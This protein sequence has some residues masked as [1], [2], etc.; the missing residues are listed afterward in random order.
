MKNNLSKTKSELTKELEEL[1]HAYAVLQQKYDEKATKLISEGDFTKFTEGISTAVFIYQ[2]DNFV[3]FNSAAKEIFG[4]SEEEFYKIKFW[5]LVHPDFRQLVKERGIARQ[6]GEHVPLNYEFKIITKNGNEKWLDYTAGNT[7][8]KGKPAVIGSAFDITSRKNTEQELLKFKLC[9]QGSFE[10]TFITDIDGTI[11]FANPAFETIYGYNQAEVIGNTPRILKSGTFSPEVYKNFW[12]T[13]LS[14]KAVA[15]EIINKTKNG[16]LISVEGFNT[17]ILDAD[18]N[19]FGFIGIHRDITEQKKSEDAI[20]LFKTLIDQSNDAI[21]VVDAKTGRFVNVNERGLIDLGYSREEFLKLNVWDVDPMVDESIFAKIVEQLKIA[22]NRLW[23]GRHKR[24]DGTTFP[25][26]VNIKIVSL[27]KDYLV[28]VV[29]DITK[30]KQTEELVQKLSRAVE[31]SPVSI[32]ITNKE[33][34]IEYINPKVTETSGFQAQ[35]VIGSNPRIFGSGEK[36]KEEYKLLWDRI[37]SGKDWFGEF[38]NKKKTGEL[39]WESVSISPIKNQVG[40]ITH[41][42]AIKEDISELKRTIDEL[43]A[44]KEKATESDRLKSAFL[45]T[46]SHELRTPLNAII[47][48]SEMFNENL[49]TEEVKEYG[50]IIHSSGNQ[51]LGIVEDIFDITLIEAGNIH[52][53]MEE[54]LLKS[55]IIKVQE[56]I[57]IDQLRMNKQHI[58][59][60]YDN[61]LSESLVIHTDFSKLKQILSN[62]IRNAL[63]FTQSGSI[64]YGYTLINT[65]ANPIIQFYVKDTGIGIPQEKL[66][67]IF[68][69]FR[70]VED[71]NIR[72]FGGTGI[73]LSITKKLVE[74]LGGNIWVESTVGKGTTFYFTLPGAIQL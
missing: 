16:K 20:K 53:S 13:L 62:L 17:S 41:F 55:V 58:N 60:Q 8:W 64:N 10:A 22:G 38:H 49:N 14:K 65:E 43:T 2:G 54:V 4:Y 51:L 1:R 15:G 46:M 21:E 32:I 24:K 73:G 3:Y 29:R 72:K 11:I 9:I 26:E 23:E 74:L 42:V 52:I 40:E 33:G 30:R 36:T 34:S 48:F 67:I 7:Y 59:L 56:I 25:V 69:M 35:E 28:T 50:A 70:Q 45:A 6:Q 44:A 39:Y 5:D 63:K 19:I 37:N 18:G 71:S 27:D 57:K 68:E 31:Q 12:D 61:S 66:E 47:G